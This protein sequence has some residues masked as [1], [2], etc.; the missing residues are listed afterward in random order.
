MHSEYFGCDAEDDLENDRLVV[1][2]FCN[3][4]GATAIF[5][6][7]ESESEKKNH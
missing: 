4:C 2:M 7:P 3:K 1:E 6:E 5:I